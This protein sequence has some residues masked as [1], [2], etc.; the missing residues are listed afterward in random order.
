MGANVKYLVRNSL[1]VT[2]IAAFVWTAKSQDK[3]FEGKILSSAD[4]VTEGEKVT[5]YVEL[6]GGNVDSR[7]IGYDWDL[8]GGRIV[9]GEETPVIVASTA[10]QGAYGTLT[11]SIEISSAKCYGTATRSVYVRRKGPQSNADKFWEW[12][13]LNGAR[14]QFADVDET[15]A[16]ESEIRQRLDEI[17]PKLTLKLGPKNDQ[18][19]RDLLVGYS[20]KPY[21]SKAVTEFVARAPHIVAFRMVFE[22]TS[23]DFPH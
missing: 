2:L 13:W 3:C 9:S 18:G 20:G 23:I 4:V 6:T 5:F 1:I 10:G 14:V 8:K 16:I 7:D 12:L 17:D 15:F 11:A 19:I 21:D 22:N